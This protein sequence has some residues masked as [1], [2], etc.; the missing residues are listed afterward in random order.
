[1]LLNYKINAFYA[2]WVV[3]QYVYI[4]T[5]VT[6]IIV[7]ELGENTRFGDGIKAMIN[8]CNQ[9]CQKGSYTRTDS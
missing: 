2:R 5:K 1:M 9:I 3:G 4:V 8:I 7:C 6:K